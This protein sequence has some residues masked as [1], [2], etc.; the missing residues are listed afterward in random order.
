M[1]E[2]RRAVIVGIALRPDKDAGREES[3]SEHERKVFHGVMGVV[4][5]LLAQK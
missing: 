1:A 5:D 3:L 2:G 4:R